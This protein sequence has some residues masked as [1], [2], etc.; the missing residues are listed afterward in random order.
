METQE[1]KRMRLSPELGSKIEE[2]NAFLTQVLKRFD[3]V[4]YANSLGAEAMVLTDVLSRH[5]PGVEIFTLDTGRLHE[6]SYRLLEEVQQRYDRRIKVYYPATEAVESY[7]NGYGIN[8]FYRDPE[9]RQSCCHIRK[10]EP[11]SR[12]IAGKEAWIT[13]VRRGQSSARA[14]AKPVE[15]DADNGLYKVSPLLQ[16]EDDEIWAYVRAF[17]LPYNPL[18]DQGFPS[19]GCAPCTRAIRAGEGNRDGRWW[20]ESSTHK[21]CGLQPRIRVA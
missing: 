19:I 15:W 18:H 4:A 2:L 11:F 12:A 5:F 13:G 20:W 17:Q 8:G 14:S 1:H 10:V 6:E 16:W 3:D 9:L 7:V 21:E